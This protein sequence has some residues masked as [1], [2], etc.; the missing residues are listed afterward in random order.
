MYGN[1][2]RSLREQR[3]MTQAQLAAIL[4]IRQSAV[5]NMENGLVQFSG[6]DK[7]RRIAEALGV[8]VN[9]L[10][11]AVPTRIDTSAAQPEPQP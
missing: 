2:I 10:V 6:V 8:P 3:G 4:G 7:M 11:A 5:A 9:D 1:V